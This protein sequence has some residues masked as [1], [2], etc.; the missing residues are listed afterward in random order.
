MEVVKFLLKKEAD[1]NIT[2]RNGCNPLDLA[3]KNG[4]KIMVDFFGQRGL[5]INAKTGENALVRA[6]SESDVDFAYLLVRR[7]A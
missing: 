7:G 2:D 3:A 5:H 4:D 6:L 1:F